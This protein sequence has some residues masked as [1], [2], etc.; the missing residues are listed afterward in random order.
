[1][2]YIVKAVRQVRLSIFSYYLHRI[3]LND[4]FWETGTSR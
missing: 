1:M 2:S 3:P 4:V